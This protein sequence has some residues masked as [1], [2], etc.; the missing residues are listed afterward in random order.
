MFSVIIFAIYARRLSVKREDLFGRFGISHYL[1][2]VKNLRFIIFLAI[3]FLSALAAVAAKDAG[4]DIKADWLSRQLE[5]PGLTVARRL[6]YVDSLIALAENDARRFSLCR[7]KIDMLYSLGRYRQAVDFIDS[8][9]PTVPADSLE[10]QLYTKLR[11]AFFTFALS[12]YSAALHQTYDLLNMAKPDSLRHYDVNACLQL[13]DFYQ[14]MEAPHLA[15]KYISKALK[16]LDEVPGADHFDDNE[17]SRF[18]GICLRLSADVYLTAGQCDSAYSEIV[19]SRMFVRDE[20]SQITENT[21]LGIIAMKRGQPAMAEDYFRQ[22]LTVENGSFNRNFAIINYMRLLLDQRRDDEA[23]ALT[24]TYTADVAKIFGAPLERQYLDLLTEYYR[25]RGDSAEEAVILRR[26]VSL[27]DSLNSAI[28]GMAIQ[29]IAS[30]YEDVTSASK[31]AAL[32]SLSRKRLWWII[33]LCVFLAGAVGVVL[34]MR[35]R[36]AA[37]R[38]AE[39]ELRRKIDRLSVDHRDALA[40]ARL[41]LESNG[42]QLASMTMLMTRLNEA[43]SA[44]VREADDKNRQPEVRLKAIKGLLADLDREENVWNMFRTYF[45]AV[46]QSFFDRLYRLAPTLTNAE[47]RMC[48]FILV[49]LTTKEIAIL[50]NRSVRTVETIKHNLRKKLSIDGP[51]EAFMRRISTATPSEFDAMIEAG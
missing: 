46:N 40:N 12:D 11:M 13:T 26:V 34:A 41:S 24:R 7:V 47:I 38:R 17:R 23:I 20:A 29:E 5:T 16:L 4:A 42:R 19:R 6:N 36:L 37:R 8:L 51:S 9:A 49:N 15:R 2:D 28:I 25:R 27:S 10:L 31:I 32:D 3:A 39:S 14:T 21:I 33:A 50:T 48:A 18:K 1:T 43:L 30:R 44:V 35:R 22:A 45:E